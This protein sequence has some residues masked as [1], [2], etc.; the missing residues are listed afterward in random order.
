[1]TFAVTFRGAD[2]ALREE[3]VE[4]ASRGECFAQ[5]K[6]RGIVPVSVKEGKR[7]RPKNQD[8]RDTQDTRDKRRAVVVGVMGVLGVLGVMVPSRNLHRM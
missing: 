2:G 5:M 8:T 4:A 1:M 3:A 6:A 7:K